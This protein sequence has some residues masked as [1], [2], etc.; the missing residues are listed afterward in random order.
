MRRSLRHDTL[1]SSTTVAQDLGNTTTT[2]ADSGS[3]PQL[4][5][6]PPV[7]ALPSTFGSTGT[8]TVVV[9]AGDENGTRLKVL[10]ETPSLNS[11]EYEYLGTC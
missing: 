8:L 1:E 3:T 7:Y 5:A 2:A 4:T 11:L 9:G 6:I 10:L